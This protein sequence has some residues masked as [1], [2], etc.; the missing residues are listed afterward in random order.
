MATAPFT[1]GVKDF[2]FF[3][4]RDAVINRLSRYE[5]QVLTRTGAAGRT[6]IRNKIRR[7]PKSKSGQARS[8]ESIYPR[9]HGSS[10]LGLR[11]ILFFY[12]PQRKSVV[13]GPF[14]Y[15]PSGWSRRDRY[16]HRFVTNPVGKTV[17]QLLNEGGHAKRKDEWP[18]GVTKSRRVR[19]RRFPFRDDSVPAIR[20]TKLA[21]MRE[22]AFVKGP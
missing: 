20:D 21:L 17:P 5:R 15:N 4:D 13:I 10:K 2:A 22:L 9:Y 1:V 16:G 19:Y 3:F 7:A 18:S 6:I 8:K 12:S 14:R 11:Q